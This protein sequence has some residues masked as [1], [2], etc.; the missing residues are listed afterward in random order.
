MGSMKEYKKWTKDN[1]LLFKLLQEEQTITAQFY[2]KM[3]GQT[4]WE[5][6]EKSSLVQTMENVALRIDQIMGIGLPAKL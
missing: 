2:S 4:S 6:Q 1:P 3:S 5:L